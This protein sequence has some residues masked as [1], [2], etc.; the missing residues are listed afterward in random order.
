MLRCEMCGKVCDLFHKT[1]V[2]G[3]ILNLCENCSSYGTILEIVKDEI[4]EEIIPEKKKIEDRELI[5]DGF[6]ALIRERREKR[7]M[8]QEEVAKAIAEKESV[9]RSVESESIPMGFK[10]AK[11]FEQFFK[12]KLIYLESEL[13]KM[14]NF[15]QKKVDIHDENVTIGDLIKAKMAN[16][17]EKKI[18][19]R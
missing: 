5:I 8:T 2:E 3:S 11:K 7:K 12:I 17:K 10:L 4:P 16:S 14:D 1:N 18:D 6:G 15:V 9:I 19:E 13:S